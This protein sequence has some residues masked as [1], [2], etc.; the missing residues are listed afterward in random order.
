MATLSA[1]LAEHVHHTRFDQLPSD[2]IERAKLTLLDTLAVAWAGLGASGSGPVRQL[3]VALGGR[4]DATAWGTAQRL[5]AAEAA[6]AN[7]VAAAALDYDALHVAGT[8]HADIVAVPAL[9]A[10]AE[11]VHAS[12]EEFLASY[13]LAQD[14]ICRL[15]LSVTRYDG[16]FNTSVLGVFGA[17]AG[18]ARLLGLGSEAITH[19]LGLALPQA[20]G[21]QQPMLEQSQ[22]KRLQSAFAARAG[23][24]AA[25]LA[26]QGLNAPAQALEG[27]YGLFNKYTG[28]NAAVLLQG[29]GSYWTGQDITIK[30]YPNCGCSHAALDLTLAL[31][32]QNGLT[33]NTVDT[34]EVTLPAF[35]QRLVGAPF[36]PAGNPQVSAQFSVRY[37]LAVALRDRQFGLPHIEADAALDPAIAALAAKVRVNTDPHAQGRMYPVSVTLGAQGQRY[38]RRAEAAS[39]SVI[40]KQQVLDKARACFA[41][42]SAPDSVATGEGLIERVLTLETLSDIRQLLAP[43]G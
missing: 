22:T 41:Y 36:V 34:I 31:I 9:L 24:T 7:G 26:A 42:A 12:G 5:P 27:D 4:P 33:P 37:A 38:S 23:V 30:R 43:T 18:A 29:L 6:F 8:V 20:G 13:V 16:W 14:L 19:A 10:V 40:D 1:Q 28:N 17:A 2:V 25:L 21:T 39:A 15:G 11:Q 3:A 32:E 35:S